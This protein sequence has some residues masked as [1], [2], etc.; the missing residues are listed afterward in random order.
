[1]SRRCLPTRIARALSACPEFSTTRGRSRTPVH[2]S[3]REIG[4]AHTDRSSCLVGRRPYSHASRLHGHNGT[5]SQLFSVLLDYR[6]ADSALAFCRD[7]DQANDTRVLVTT[8][9][10]QL[11]KVLVE[12]DEDPLL[13]V[14]LLENLFVTG[15]GP[16]SPVC[17]M[18]CLADTS[19]ACAPRETQVSSNSFIQSRPRS[20]AP[21]VRAPPSGARRLN[22]HECRQIPA[23]GSFPG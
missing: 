21:L 4:N 7:S 15:S 2:K 11:A 1:M 12:L 20:M 16:D 18:S 5:R 9:N 3:A 22:R 14:S 6:L 13:S 10:R 17:T 23:M 8:D 19:S